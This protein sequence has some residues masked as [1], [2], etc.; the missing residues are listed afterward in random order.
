MSVGADWQALLAQLIAVTTRWLV[1]GG[2]SIRLVMG[3]VKNDAA[4]IERFSITALRRP[5]TAAARSA[6]KFH[7]P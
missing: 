5:A 2:R 1:D 3:N 6:R 4:L 7:C